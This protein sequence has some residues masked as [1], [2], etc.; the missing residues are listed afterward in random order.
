MYSRKKVGL[1]MERSGTPTLT[2]YSCE[3]FPSTTTPSHLLLRKEEIG[4]NI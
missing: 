1:K 3:N 4:P 2:R